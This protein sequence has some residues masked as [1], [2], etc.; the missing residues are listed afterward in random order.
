MNLEFNVAH[1]GPKGRDGADGPCR[2]VVS[3]SLSGG[4]ILDARLP[5]RLHDL[6]TQIYLDNE[7]LRVD[8]FQARNGA[9]TIQLQLERQGWNANSPLRL[10][11][12]TRQLQ[13]D[14]HFVEV[15]PTHLPID[16]QAI[17]RKYYPA[18][19]IDADVRL[20]F[21]GKTWK[22]EFEIECDDVSF[23]YH[24]FPYRAERT[25][26]KLSLKDNLL[27]IQLTTSAGGQ[28][29]TICGQV[30]NPGPAQTLWIELDCR[31]PIPLDEDLISAVRNPKHQE[32]VRSLRPGGTITFFGR[33][34][35]PDPADHYVHK[36]VRIDLFNCSLNYKNFPY[37]FGMIRGTLRW[38]DAGWTFENLSGRNDS[39]YVEC[40]G[41]WKP[42]ADGGSLLALTFQGT[43]VPLEDELREALSPGVK[44]LWTQ[45][46][47]RGSVDHLAVELRYTSSRRELQLE[48]QAQKWKKE[49]NGESRS[50]TIEPT[51][52]PYRLDDVAGTAHYWNGTVQLK[53]ITAVHGQTEV[54]LNGTCNMR[55]D[56]PWS[57]DLSDVTADGLQFDRELLSALPK[58]LGKAVGKLNLQG[59][60]SMR[61]ALTFAGDSLHA[62]STSAAWNV[63]LDV[64]NGQLQCGLA[65]DHLHGD[66]HLNGASDPRGYFS[67]GE[68][69]LDSLM[70]RNLQFTQVRGP[71]LVDS[72]GLVLG[73]E[74][75]RD[76]RDG[77]PRSLTGQAIGG[78]VTLESAVS[79]DGDVPFR[80]QA[81]LE[82]GDLTEM[83]RELQLPNPNIQGK[84]NALMTLTGN[85][86][87]E[88]SWR[89]DGEIYL[90]DAD[91]Y[92]VP[93]MVA[94]LKVL[95][96]RRPDTTGFTSSEIGFHLE[97]EHVYFKKIDLDGDAISLR[98]RRG[99]M[100]LD[101][102][103]DLE[104][105]TRVGRRDWNL[106]PITAILSQASKQMLLIR[107]SG[108]LD[109][110][111]LTRE[112]LPALN[113]A[114]DQLFP[115]MANRERGN[116]IIAV[117]PLFPFNLRPWRR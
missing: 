45:L 65:L 12:Q 57:V 27:D 40:N 5:G 51:W 78:V 69:N 79:F 71:L 47:P 49:P 89:G 105:Y 41:S 81:R 101:R 29:V 106:P 90:F 110:P 50:I 74:A 11:A 98:L 42:T 95:S 93:V 43:D 36:D 18:G 32:I 99:E 38:N 102:Q 63:T 21:D 67:R 3:G 117:D 59:D 33:F 66:V 56:G 19:T 8:G 103:I 94:L 28:D 48:V 25:R 77:A 70:Y 7:R 62:N 23:A 84:A 15:L 109:E 91:I 9:S 30:R 80:V 72:T 34:D 96:I 87:G 82:R 10:T 17:W 31:Q 113:E 60:I 88:P 114:L 24:L 104:F 35:K 83:A 108:T 52:F 16:L 39:G 86:Y 54:S 58:E 4:E 13:L 22:P 97:G 53:K 75:E 85:R 6:Q 37:P 2:F 68:L 64:E 112:P 26:G 73:M 44:R 100:G 46:R 115:E 107:A 111:H 92:Q 55:N 116:G 61:G 1:G 14:R 76:V 20:D